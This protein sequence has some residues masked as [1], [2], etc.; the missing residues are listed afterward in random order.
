MCLLPCPWGGLSL[1]YAGK[2]LKCDLCGGAPQCVE[3]CHDG[4]IEYLS[5]EEVE[6]KL[7]WAESEGAAAQEEIAEP[8]IDLARRVSAKWRGWR[9]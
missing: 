3:H 6:R 1:D 9:G 7:Q 4:A 2:I 5:R 8:E